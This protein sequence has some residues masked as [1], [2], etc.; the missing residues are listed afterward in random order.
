RIMIENKELDGFAATIQDPI[1]AFMW[2]AY[3]RMLITN[4]CI[5]EDIKCVAEAQEHT[6][7]AMALAPLLI[8]AMSPNLPLPVL[9]PPMYTTASTTPAAPTTPTPSTTKQTPLIPIPGMTPQEFLAL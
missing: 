7:T 3:L 8:L 1:V 4:E 9:P 6:K 2:E 5:L